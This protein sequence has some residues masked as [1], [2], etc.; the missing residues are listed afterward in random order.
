MKWRFI[1]FIILFLI[2][3]Q[4]AL[5]E[6]QINKL[7]ADLKITQAKI[8]KNET[9]IKLYSRKIKEKEQ[10]IKERQ[11]AMARSFRFLAYAD[12]R[13]FLVSFL[14]SK[15]L[16]DFLNQ[17]E[18]LA[19]L[20]NGL[21]EDYKILAQDKVELTSLLFGQEELKKDFIDFKN[22]LQ[23][24]SRLIENQKKEK[25]ALL[26]ETKNQET[27]Y[28]KIIFQIQVK[29]AQIQKEI[30]ELENKLRWEVTGVPLARPGE[31]ALALFW[32]VSQ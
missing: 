18:Y 11:A 26:K 6:S 21:Y 7:K 17:S 9:N 23:A 2:V 30:L 27:E 10:K 13:G 25:G 12:D 1:I 5:V 29:Q 14:Q 4:I 22:E 8:S 24:K 20:A 16:S 3:S 28:Q 32:G 19:N 31:L 15:K